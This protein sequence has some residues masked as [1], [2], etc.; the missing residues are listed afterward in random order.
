[1]AE[2][3]AQPVL[4]SEALDAPELADVVRDDRAAQRHGMRCNQKVVATNDTARAF[5]RR[6]QTS[7]LTWQ[8]WQRMKRL[9]DLWLPPARLRHSLPDVSFDV[10]TQGRSSVR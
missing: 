9:T 7:R 5:E 8:R 4:D 3:S 2:G 6:S 10:T 1:M